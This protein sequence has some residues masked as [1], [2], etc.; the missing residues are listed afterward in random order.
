MTSIEAPDLGQDLKCDR[1]KGQG[2]GL[3]L[4]PPGRTQAHLEEGRGWN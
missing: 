4:Q 3:G 2:G 1:R